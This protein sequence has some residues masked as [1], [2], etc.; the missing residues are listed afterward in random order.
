MGGVFL[1][2][3]AGMG[4]VFLP[5][6]GC[7]RFWGKEGRSSVPSWGRDGQGV[8]LLCH[9]ATHAYICI[10]APK[11]GRRRGGYGPWHLSLLSA[12]PSPPGRNR[13]WGEALKPE[14]ATRVQ[15]LLLSYP[16]PPHPPHLLQKQHPRLPSR[17][18]LLRPGLGLGQRPSRPIRDSEKGQ[19]RDPSLSAQ[20]SWDGPQ[21]TS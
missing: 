9:P 17:P 3:P 18:L 20:I 16:L 12:V 21:T 10:K 1:P 5:P 7:G 4:G 6:P 8:S 2:P 19:S 15:G 14:L 11:P 13:G